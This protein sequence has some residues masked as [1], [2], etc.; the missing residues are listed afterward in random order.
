[1]IGL[2][3]AAV[4][5]L[6]GHSHGNTS[7]G[8]SLAHGE[9]TQSTRRQGGRDVGRVGRR[10]R[11][12]RAYQLDRVGTFVGVA[13][14]VAVPTRQLHQ[15]VEAHRLCGSCSSPIGGGHLFGDS[16]ALTHLWPHGTCADENMARSAPSVTRRY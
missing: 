7:G 6:P 11:L 5:H 8:E 1:V 13:G 10:S 4:R 16:A 9:A 15:R 2:V 12:A 3:S 14:V